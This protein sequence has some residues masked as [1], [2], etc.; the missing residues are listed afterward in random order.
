MRRFELF[1][2]DQYPPKL[3]NG[4]NTTGYRG[5]LCSWVTLATD[6]QDAINQL[7]SFYLKEDK[8]GPKIIT[9]YDRAAP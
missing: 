8:Q 3:P 9:A 7:Y 4:I 6:L 2:V 5:S 1:W